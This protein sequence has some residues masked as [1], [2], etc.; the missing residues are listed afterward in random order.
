[1]IFGGDGVFPFAAHHEHGRGFAAFLGRGCAKRRL[2][3]DLDTR[4]LARR[5]HQRNF[6]PLIGEAL[7]GVARGEAN[8]FVAEF[9]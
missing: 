9:A 2:L 3:I 1:M 6:A 5:Q 8:H 7:H 4:Q